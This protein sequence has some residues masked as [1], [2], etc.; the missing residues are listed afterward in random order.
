MQKP[1]LL[2]LQDKIQLCMVTYDKGEI[3]DLHGPMQCVSEIGMG[4]ETF[5]NKLVELLAEALHTSKVIEMKDLP[6]HMQEDI[7]TQLEDQSS[8]ENS[9]SNES[10]ASSM[11]ADTSSSSI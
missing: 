11:A 3:V 7:N 8:S 2:K 4:G 5:V 9:S 10:N 6:I 1:R